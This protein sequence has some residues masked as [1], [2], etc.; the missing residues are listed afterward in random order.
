MTIAEVILIINILIA[1]TIIFLERKD[2]SATLAWIMLLIFVP[3]LGIIFY[4]VFSQNVSRQKI[5]KMYENEENVVASSLKAQNEAMCENS[6]SFTNDVAERWVDLIKLNQTCAYAYY[7]QDSRLELLTDG[8][9]KMKSLFDD[10]ENAK[11]YINIQY[12]IV[13]KDIIGDT[14]LKLLIRK[15]KQGVEVRLLV[16]ALG[17]RGINKELVNMLVESGGQYAEFFPTKFKL[18]N[19]K[20]NYRNHRK[21]VVIDNKIGYIGGF[22]IAREY[23]GMK[24][25]FGY[26]RDTHVRV[27]GSSVFDLNARFLLDWRS[28]TR[29]EV[30]LT[31]AFMPISYNF[32]NSGVQIVS[33]GPDNTNE[34]IKHAFLKMI[35]SAKKSIYI[36]TPYFVP[37]APILEPLKMAAQ[38][39]V[40]VNVM[41]PCMPDHM[42]VYWATYSFVAELIDVGAKVYIYDNGF[43]HAKV[44]VADEVCT[45]GSTNFDRRSFRLNFEAN[46]FIYDSD[47]TKKVVESFKEDI[48]KS[49]MLTKELYEQRGVIIKIKEVFSRMLSDVL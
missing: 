42:F 26:W 11:E 4:I 35:T 40:E 38:S 10:I 18:F 32:G 39:G 34:A 43:L 7:T 8:K 48:E 5:F 30:D 23:V 16:D 41:I 6:F 14:L 20:L 13:K 15:A 44:L 45:I 37:D 49:H 19:T 25:K 3:I 31:R 2:S 24:R 9:E 28:A 22:N 17:S 36:Q 46:A 1:L 47:F 27:K 33:S 21:L 29:E 12:F